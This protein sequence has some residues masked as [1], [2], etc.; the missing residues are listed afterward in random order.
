M[1]SEIKRLNDTL[2]TTK[3]NYDDLIR[4]MTLKSRDEESKKSSQITKSYETR[5]RSLDEARDQLSRKNQDL[6]RVIQDKEQHL[7]NNERDKH[8]QVARLEHEIT[9][10][11]GKIE[12]MTYMLEKANNDAYERATAKVTRDVGNTD[13]TIQL[14]QQLDQRR[15]EIEDKN[16]SIRELKQVLKETTSEAERKRIDLQERC[17]YYE[18]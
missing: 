13:E 17:S 7:Q 2:L 5:L 10:L 15:R 18:A 8:E 1:E 4:E 6:L 14:K 12:H 9:D 3:I 16:A 11:H